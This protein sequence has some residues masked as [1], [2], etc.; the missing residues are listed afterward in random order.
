MI[1]KIFAVYDSKVEAY[2]PP[3]FMA[4]RGQAIRAFVDSAT[5][6]STQLGK[7][8][9]DFTL[10]ELGEYDDSNARF[11]IHLTPISLGIASELLPKV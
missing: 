8:P 5:D 2:L 3:F 9:T 4:A 11:T 10:F 6:S 1:H 7:H